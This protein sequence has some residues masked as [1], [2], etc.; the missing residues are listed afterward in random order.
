MARVSD[1]VSP[2]AG[3]VSLFGLVTK[4]PD[5]PD[6][7]AN[8]VIG[9]PVPE[10]TALLRANGFR[11]IQVFDADARVGLTLDLMPDRRRLFE[12]DGIVVQVTG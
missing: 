1:R 8:L 12:R 9:L 4:L 6:Y 3:S 5:P 2:Y 11:V 10:A 7:D